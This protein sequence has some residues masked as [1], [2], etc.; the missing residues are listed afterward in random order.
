MPTALGQHEQWADAGAGWEEAKK[1]KNHK[2]DSHIP[3]AWNLSSAWALITLSM[4][5]S[6]TETRPTGRGHG[7]VPGK[8][9]DGEYL[10]CFYDFFNEL[11]RYFFNLMNIKF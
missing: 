7:H 9:E 11:N 3:P 1:K 10:V 6:F 2:V 5:P 8:E 4:A